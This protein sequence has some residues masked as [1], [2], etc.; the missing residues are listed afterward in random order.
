MRGGEALNKAHNA[1]GAAMDIADPVK[2]ADA[3][4]EVAKLYDAVG[5]AYGKRNAKLMR[6]GA[7]KLRAKAGK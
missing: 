3:Y 7:A 2:R 5:T 1:A 4:E 6:S